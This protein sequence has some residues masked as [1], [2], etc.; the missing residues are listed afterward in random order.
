MGI[1]GVS[2]SS[3]PEETQIDEHI[4]ALTDRDANHENTELVG[5]VTKIVS[6]QQEPGL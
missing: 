4:F 3:P 5:S 2:R 1:I 6:N